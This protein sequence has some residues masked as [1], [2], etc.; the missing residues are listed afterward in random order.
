MFSK[1]KGARSEFPVPVP[2]PEIQRDGEQVRLIQALQSA[3][4][5]SKNHSR[6]ELYCFH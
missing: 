5:P 2:R 4:H 6:R 3:G 1:K